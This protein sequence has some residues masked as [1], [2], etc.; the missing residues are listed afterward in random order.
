MRDHN[1]HVRLPRD[2]VS[3]LD[4]NLGLTHI[5]QRADVPLKVTCVPEVPVREIPIEVGYRPAL[6]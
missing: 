1:I 4:V 6:L 2:F 3:N 5:Q